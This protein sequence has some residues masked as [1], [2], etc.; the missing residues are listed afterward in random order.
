M[1]HVTILIILT[2]INNFQNVF[3]LTWPIEGNTNISSTHGE[4]RAVYRLHQGVDIPSYNEEVKAA[5]SGEAIF[6]YDPSPRGNGYYVQLGDYCYFHLMP[7][8]KDI[9]EDISKYG[10]AKRPVIE[11]QVIGRSDTSGTDKPHL[12]FRTGDINPLLLFSIPDINNGVIEKVYFRHGGGLVEI[13][14]GMVFNRANPFPAS[15]EFIVNAY[16]VSNTGRNHVNFYRIVSLLDGDVLRDWEFNVSHTAEASLVYSISNP[17]ST[18]SEFWYRMGDWSSNEGKHTLTIEGYDLNDKQQRLSA[19]KTIKFIIDYTPPEVVIR[20]P[21]KIIWVPQS[22]WPKDAYGN[23]SY[24]IPISYP[25]EI[26]F[27]VLDNIA[28]DDVN[29]YVDDRLVSSWQ[30]LESDIFLSTTTACGWKK[31]TLKISAKDLA[32]NITDYS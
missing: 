23:P 17:A 8:S 25:V 4:F 18:R 13:R 28:V 11:G 30:D 22:Q 7:H 24:K 29:V 12:H 27:D 14:D 32:G 15:G 10:F 5:I 31:H 3:S 1:K 26:S 16:D 2:I 9:M 6:K 20:E 21:P 19:T